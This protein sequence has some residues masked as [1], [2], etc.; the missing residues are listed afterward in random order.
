MKIS[1]I[2]SNTT[3]P[4]EDVLGNK[5]HPC[6]WLTDGAAEAANLYISAFQSGRVLNKTYFSAAAAEVSGQKQGSECTVDIEV[7][8]QT[9]QLLNGGPYFQHSPSMSLFAVCGSA[10]EVDAIYAKLSPG[11]KTLLAL[12]EY[13]FSRRYAFFSDKFG[14]HWQ[15]MLEEG[16]KPRI[17]PCILFGGEK[18]GTGTKALEFYKTLFKNTNVLMDER[19]GKNQGAPEGAIMHARLLLEGSPLVIMDGNSPD[20]MPMSGALSLVVMCDD[21]KEVDHYWEKIAAKGAEAQCGWINDEFGVTWQIVP[22]GL[23]ELVTGDNEKASRAFKAMADMKKIDFET[24]RR[25][26]DGL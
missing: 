17:I 1:K 21:Q 4:R 12:G 7:A 25:A 15:L 10:Q 16:A 24:I 3:K 9:L 13:P 26:Y 11:G 8:G 22:R 5:L 2:T 18:Q 6:I 14:V 20:P 23:D 19:Y